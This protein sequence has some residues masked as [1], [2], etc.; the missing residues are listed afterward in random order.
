MLTP[1][2]DDGRAEKLKGEDGR[3]E[4]LYSTLHTRWHSG[5]QRLQGYLSHKKQHPPR[6]LQ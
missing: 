4:R 5:V 3:K 1:E 2:K 6:T